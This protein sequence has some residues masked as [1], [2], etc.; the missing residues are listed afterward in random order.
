MVTFVVIFSLVEFC[1][2]VVS[3]EGQRP[4]PI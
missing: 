3:E 1:N 2:S 4:S